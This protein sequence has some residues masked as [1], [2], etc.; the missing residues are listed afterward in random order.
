MATTEITGFDIG[1]LRTKVALL[2]RVAAALYDDNERAS[3][4][5]E[6]IC[7]RLTPRGTGDPDTDLGAWRAC[8]VLLEHLE[9]VTLLSELRK[10]LEYVAAALADAEKST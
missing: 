1:K 2:Q 10:D 3:S 4:V 5:A 6:L 7:T 9:D 8:E